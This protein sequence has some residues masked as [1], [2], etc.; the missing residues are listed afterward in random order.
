M[1]LVLRDTLS[2]TVSGVTLG[3]VA[4]AFVTRLL[5]GLLFGVAPLDPL[6]FAGAAL[7]FLAVALL[8]SVMPARRALSVSAAVALRAD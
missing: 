6:T 2:L 7:V 4:A 3:L 5:S 8:A 1:R